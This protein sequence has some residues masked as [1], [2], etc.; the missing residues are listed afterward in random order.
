M[1][2]G[3]FKN[4]PIRTA[5]E[6]VL[7]DKPFDITENLKFN[8]YQCGYSST[9]YNFFEKKTFGDTVKSD[10]MPNQ[11]LTED[12]ASQLLDSSKNEQYTH[13]SWTAFVVLT[14]P[15]CN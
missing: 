4:L 14:L 12:Y 11:E 8:G 15:I 13:L 5:A 2:Y 9:F 1:A 7:S 10:V 3:N 6:K